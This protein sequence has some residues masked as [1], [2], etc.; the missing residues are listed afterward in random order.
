VLSELRVEGL[1]VIADVSLLLGPGMTVLTGETGAGKTML[2]EAIA[3][4]VGERADAGLVRPGAAEA[5]VEGRFVVGDEEV[6]LARVIPAE[7]RSRAYVDGRLATVGQL[8]EAGWRLADLHGQ[9]AHQSLLGAAV[10]RGALDRFGAVDLGPLRA[11]RARLAE[12]D[13]ALAELGGDGRARAREVDLLRFQVGEIAAASL[14]SVHEDEEL[15]AEEDR[16][17]GVQAH[18]EAGERALASLSGDGGA[19]DGLRAA[20]ADLERHGP[21]AD[22]AGRLRSLAVELDDAAGELRDAAEGLEEDPERLAAVRERRHRL[23]ELRRKYGDTLAGVLAFG[24]EAAARLAELEGWEAR[25]AALEEERRS[26]SAVEALAAAAVAA[27]RRDAAPRLAEAVRANLAALA[28]PRARVEVSVAGPGPADDVVFLLGANPGEPVAPLAKVASGGE[29][30]RAMLALRLVL[31]EAPDTLVF[32]EVDAGIG[33]EAALAVGRSLAELGTRHQVLVVTHLAQ[34]AAF[35]DTQVAVSKEES[36]GRTVARAHPVA[37]ED[38]TR[39]LSRML[40]GLATSEPARRH[41]EELLATA[42]EL[43]ASRAGS[44]SPAVLAAAQTG[45]RARAGRRR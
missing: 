13:A 24:E 25:A 8:A 11:A 1:G 15:D 37:G 21:F 34:V 18:R 22:L 4:L 26:V 2:V 31:T 19:L 3:L 9:H 44:G 5:R 40:S 36:G 23:H 38:R 17:A 20:V 6:V 14:A 30:A 28:M 41:A 45:G 12:I 43:R 39:E 42:A 35:A 29:L 7:G 27:A 10:Q 32:D 16:L 33:G